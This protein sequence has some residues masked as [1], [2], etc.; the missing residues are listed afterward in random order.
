M[1]GKKYKVNVLSKKI[2]K[3]FIDNYVPSINKAKKCLNLKIKYDSFE[4]VSNV[5][6][7]LKKNG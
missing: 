6:N 2:N 3:L 7:N 4:A 1:L 5:I